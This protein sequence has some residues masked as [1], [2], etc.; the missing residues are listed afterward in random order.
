MNTR[1]TMRSWTIA[2]LW[3]ALAILLGSS[4]AS[5]QV[6]MSASPVTVEVR[7]FGVGGHVR[8]G[9]WAGIQLELTD[10]GSGKAARRV[11]VQ[12]HDRD[13]DGDT[14]LVQ[15]TTTLTVG[16]ARKL[17]IPLRMPWSLTRT[18]DFTLSVRELSET[19]DAGDPHAGRQLL[20][21]RIRPNGVA[22]K[23]QPMIGIVGREDV[24]L[25]QYRMEGRSGDPVAT[26][27]EVYDIVGGLEPN[28]LPDQWMG[29]AQFEAIAWTNGDP[30]EL[31]EGRDDA[32]IEW[33][34]RGGHLVIVPP[35]VGSTWFAGRNPLASIMPVVDVTRLQGRSLEPYRNLLTVPDV[36]SERSLPSKTVVY[37]FAPKDNAK[38]NEA[39]PLFTGPDGCIVIRRIVGTG[40]VTV[41]GLDVRHRGLTTTRLLAAKALWHPILGNRFDILTA[42][43]QQT[44]QA[45]LQI[46]RGKPSLD[47]DGFI[48]E[49]ISM[50]AAAG[51]GVLLALVVFGVY[52][53]LAGPGGYGLLNARGLVH[54]AWV[55]FVMIVAVFAGIAWTG[56]KAISP[57]HFE[58]AHL[59]FLDQ[60]YGEGV[61]HTRTYAS[62]L[63]PIYGEGTITVGEPGLD[64]DF[65]QSIAPW[66]E[67]GSGSLLSFPDQRPYAWNAAEPWHVAVP[68]RS[69]IKQFVMDW[70]GG[71]RSMDGAGGSARWGNIR[72]VNAEE[73]PRV[74]L[75]DPATTF[76]LTGR[77]MHDMGVPLRN[78][79]VVY[80]AGVR[81]E[82]ELA[83]AQD[84]LRAEAYIWSLPVTEWAS[85][86]ANAIDLS[87]LKT[88]G[89]SMQA[90]FRKHAPKSMTGLDT[91]VS[92]AERFLTWF[93]A[94]EPL[95]FRSTSSRIAKLKR[96]DAHGL[97]L[98][99]WLT[100]PCLV[101]TGEVSTPEPRA[102]GSPTPMQYGSGDNPRP[103][104]TSGET[105]LR[106]VYPLPA[107]PV[108]LRGAQVEPE[109][110]AQTSEKKTSPA[111][112]T[113]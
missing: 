53:I 49:R 18:S 82:E 57:S 96:N 42:E 90:F 35:V 36:A 105:L 50:G 74:V 10:A 69:T 5:A 1:P 86:E 79:R 84:Q 113:R 75:R 101:I 14:L 17:W 72:P 66:A 106:W 33:V 21:K 28:G 103:L 2:A 16:V 34:R 29:L 59:T 108:I 97:D 95:E 46:A 41:I 13:V 47:V 91:G 32:I 19:E 12:I 70:M 65:S 61:Q 71:P 88:S 64:E 37:S 81:S 44:H 4:P 22:G 104:P 73:V 20:A 68:A 56:A 11:I 40:M 24:A 39:S 3:G 9:E 48:G 15:R 67:D 109:E 26:W 54:H 58:A 100:Q 30:D 92:N 77:I 60:V 107:R 85:G 6:Q 8:Q 99:K 25:S 87:L 51:V 112:R 76:P 83:V 98:S 31:T 43:Q 94:V 80:V 38:L 63:L 93:G 27:H 62:C 102:M 7:F 110:Q 111:M 52:W 23:D 78:V 55:G 89:A 45:G